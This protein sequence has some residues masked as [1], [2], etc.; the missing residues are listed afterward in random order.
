MY[1]TLLKVGW[2]PKTVLDVGAYKGTWTTQTKRVFPKAKFT[3]I[4]A[5]P[6]NELNAFD[7]VIY[8]LVGKE[9]SVVEWFSNQSTGDS[10]YKETTNIYRD[11]I[12]IQKPIVKLDSLFPTK[13]F[14]YVKIDCQGAELD[15]LQGGSKLIQNTEVLLLECPF[16]AK[17]NHGC[18]SFVEYIDYTQ[19]IGFVPLEITE[20]HRA[21]DIMIQI[22]ILFLRKS[23]PLWPR[24]QAMIH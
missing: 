15:I 16:A 17:Y 19:S 18:P 22:D 6:H 1:S 7:D 8:T 9:D 2:Y 13:T 14:D 20:I 11:I 4:E 21:N 10:I 24:I 23:S 3:L 5:N 12:P